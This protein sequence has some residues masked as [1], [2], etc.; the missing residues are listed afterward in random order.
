MMAM[1]GINV[2][3]IWKNIYIII[4]LNLNFFPLNPIKAHEDGFN[5]CE[6]NFMNLIQSD[7]Q[8]IDS[9]GSCA[10]VILILNDSC[11]IG[12]LGD[13]QALYSCL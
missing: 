1:Q 9:S 3:N 8:Y 6:N 7:Y 4:Y 13:S 12:N 5:I 2:V 10:I 11:Y